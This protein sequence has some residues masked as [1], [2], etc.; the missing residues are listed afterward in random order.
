[1]ILFVPDGLRPGSV[2]LESAP[3]IAAIRD[4]G[5]SFRN[6]HSLFPTLTTSNASALATG[7]YLGDTGTYADTIHAGFPI[8]ASN[9]SV[10]AMLRSDVVL[11][12]VD[13]HCG[14]NCFGEST[15]LEAAR[16]HGISTAAIGKLGPSLIFDHT[17]RSGERTILVD[18]ATGKPDG[19]PMSEKVKDAF[20]AASIPITAPTRGEN[21]NSGDFRT[22]GT[23]VANV[24]QQ[25]Y[26][27]DVATK[28]VLPLFKARDKPFILVFWSRDPDGT[29]H[30]QGDSLL[31]LLPGVNG[32]TSLAAIR[33]ADDTLAR[34]QQSLVDLGLAATTNI[35]VASDHGFATV[36]KRSETS[37]AA[38]TAYA[39][40]AKGYL[41]PGFLA[42]DLARALDLPLFDPDKGN[43]PVAANA[44]TRG[45][46][47]IGRD[48]AR[49]DVLVCANGGSDLIYLPGNDR[50][51]VARV[52]EA[53]LAQDYV[54][55]LF[56]D[57]DFGLFPGTLPLSAINFVGDAATPRPGIV[58]NFRS[59]CTHPDA[60]LM[61]AA[62]VAD[63]DLQH[64]QGIHG[65]FS[66]AETLNFMAAIGP[67]FKTAFV[68]EAPVSTADIGRTIAHLLGVEKRNKGK[69]RGRVIREAMPRGRT[70]RFTRHVRH[71]PPNANVPR[72]TLAWQQVGEIR[73]FD[74]AGVP[75][76]TV[77]LDD[78][79]TH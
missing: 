49:P 69:L 3:T 20:R 62:L 40:V 2:T 14:G 63:T 17:E 56:V 46:A 37:L 70:P 21:G 18:D 79:L 74:A 73:Y 50:A 41:P 43:A 8:E 25:R 77:G 53:M 55:G 54:S 48:P 19:I 58:V 59:F 4:R 34:L 28:V 67:D 52:I 60:C 57:D 24:E 22:P 10:L 61:S 31:S 9:G 30:Y 13:R 64:G 45:N 39:D 16:A 29:Q 26:F 7:H 15:V 36:S 23:T 6:S 32:P 66:R 75:G 42:I 11:G 78:Y 12:E 47:A 44:H 51:L 33:N 38:G 27:T 5:V 1:V 76:R 71:S 35:I 65:S 72:M 68:D